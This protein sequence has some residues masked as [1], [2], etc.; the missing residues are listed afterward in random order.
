MSFASRQ[1]HVTL[2]QNKDKTRQNHRAVQRSSF[3]TTTVRIE[4]CR[5]L[6][7]R[8]LN[9][10]ASSYGHMH[11]MLCTCLSLKASRGSRWFTLLTTNVPQSLFTSLL[12]LLL[13]DISWTSHRLS[14]TF[15]GSHATCMKIIQ[16]LLPY[17]NSPIVVVGVNS[18]CGCPLSG[19]GR[20]SQLNVC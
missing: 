16:S 3:R 17:A 4:F 18:K 5:S 8:T 9:H 7:Q 1:R 15:M 11:F 6:C 14:W 13:L 20:W 10:L 19:F 2:R 12:S